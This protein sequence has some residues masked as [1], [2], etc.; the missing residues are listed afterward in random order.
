MDRQTGTYADLAK[1]VTSAA[2]LASGFH[3]R[4]REWRALQREQT[5]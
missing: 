1:T 4:K 3:R 2:L 5:E